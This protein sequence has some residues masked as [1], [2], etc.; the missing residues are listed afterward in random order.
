MRYI[1]IHVS[2]HLCNIFQ[3]NYWFKGKITEA[4]KGLNYILVKICNKQD[5]SAGIASQL[6]KA[7]IS[8]P[9]MITQEDGPD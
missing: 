9:L 6:S 5:V 8:G 3:H 2:P 1:Y 4:H 7:E